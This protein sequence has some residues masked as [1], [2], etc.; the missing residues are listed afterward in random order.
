[1]GIGSAA[2]GA[3]AGGLR[4][5][6]L[7]EVPPPRRNWVRMF[8]LV[9]CRAG[10]RLD[11]RRHGISSPWRSD[12]QGLAV[13]DSAPRQRLHH[14]RSAPALGYSVSLGPCQAVAARVPSGLPRVPRPCGTW[15]LLF[16]FWSLSGSGGARSLRLAEGPP[17]CGTRVRVFGCWSL[18]RC[19]GAR[20]LRLAEGPPPSGTR[21]HFFGNCSLSGGGGARS[22]RLAEGPPPCG[23][24]VKVSGFVLCQAAA[25]R[26]RSGLP[27]VPRPAG[28]VR[29]PRWRVCKGPPR[30]R[31]CKTTRWRACKTT[32]VACL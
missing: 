25:A 10:P 28:H 23:T 7:A 2:W 14:G 17:P 19:G 13:F 6:R 1:L 18:S 12:A 22:L 31:V 20:S 11:G 21:V 8:G 4:T 15:V 3:S 29:P 16:Q 26:V 24:R 27:W 5:F 32:S 9:L 30:W